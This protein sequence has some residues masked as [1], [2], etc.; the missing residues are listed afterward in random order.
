MLQNIIL[1]A[2][3]S[4]IIIF[5]GYLAFLLSSLL[6]ISKWFLACSKW[7]N[8]SS[9]SVS[10]LEGAEFEHDLVLVSKVQN[11]VIGML[12]MRWSMGLYISIWWWRISIW[13][14]WWRGCIT[15]RWRI[16]IRYE[17]VWGVSIWSGSISIWSWCL[18][19][20]IW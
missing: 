5:I 17:R 19:R 15:I 20:S 7:I 12:I 14:S 2:Y 10:T 13:C 6:A 11:R 9:L 18:S 8:I 4:I 1:K 3:I 16:S